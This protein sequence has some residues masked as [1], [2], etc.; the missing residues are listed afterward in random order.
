[1]LL[2]SHAD[3]VHTVAFSPDGRYLAC[4]D[5]DFD[6]YLWS[7]VEAAQVGLVLSGHGDEIRCLAFSADSSQLISAGAD[8]VVHVWDVNTGKLIAG[9]NA[10][11]KHTIAV[12][13]GTPLHLASTAGPTVRVWNVDNGDE[14]GPTGLFPAN[15]IAATADGSVLAVGGTDHF[16]RLWSVPGNVQAGALEATKPPVGSLAFAPVTNLLAQAS[17]TDGLVWLWQPARGRGLADPHR[18]GRR[19]HARKPG[20]PPER[21][22]PGL[23]RHRLPRHRRA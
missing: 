18:S 13:P 7:N 9:P 19:L 10:P 1:M 15:S 23:R 21:Q 22:T 6:I 12:I 14:V 11:T 17:P 20:V 5:S 3:Q 8:R 16:T 2:N 4:A